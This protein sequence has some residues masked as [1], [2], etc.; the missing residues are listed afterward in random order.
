MATVLTNVGEQHVC[1]MLSGVSSTAF[2]WVGWGT[3]AGTAAKGD[4]TLF[5]EA[6]EARIQGT[7][8]TNGSG[9]A[10]K[11]Q[12]ISTITADG[13]KTITNAGAFTAVSGGT[14]VLKGDFTGV[15]LNLGD[16]IQFTFTLDPA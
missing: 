11:Y 5:T 7:K 8:S 13:T 6:S 14:L 12:V 10:A 2:D 15:P 16:S 4:T 1:D 3:G 9:A